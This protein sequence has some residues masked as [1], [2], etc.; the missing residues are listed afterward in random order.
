MKGKVDLG[1]PESRTGSKSDFEG[2]NSG[3]DGCRDG[4]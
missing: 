2:R 1:K 3:S 4:S